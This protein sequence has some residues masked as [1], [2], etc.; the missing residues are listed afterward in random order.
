MIKMGIYQIKNLANN[1][2]YIGSSI[3][4]GSRFIAHKS[5]LKRNKHENSYLQNAYNKYSEWNFEYTILEIVS[6]KAI[7][8][9]REQYWL[10]KTKCYINGYNIM[11]KAENMLGFCHSNESKIKMSKSRKGKVSPLR[12]RNH[13]QET[14]I[15][16][17]NSHRG[18]KKNFSL[19]ARKRMSEGSKWK[20]E[21]D[22]ICALLSLSC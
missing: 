21:S 7:L 1:D 4:I 10:D 14:I 3:N 17:K 11:M 16:M 5:L 8:L 19:D 6:N 13:T 22:R 15:K 20:K 9:D 12:G 2:I 18:K